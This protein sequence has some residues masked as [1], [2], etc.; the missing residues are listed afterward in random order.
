ML[1]LRKLRYHWQIT[2]T[3]TLSEA[4]GLLFMGDPSPPQAPVQDDGSSDVI[5]F[6]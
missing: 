6:L 2:V 3:V 1:R 5:S 4:K